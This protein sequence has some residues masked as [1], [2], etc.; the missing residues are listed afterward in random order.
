VLLHCCCRPLPCTISRPLFLARQRSYSCALCSGWAVMVKGLADARVLACKMFCYLLRCEVRIHVI[1]PIS[2]IT[3]SSKAGKHAPQQTTSP[4]LV[5]RH[6][7][8]PRCADDDQIGTCM[9]FSCCR[10]SCRCCAL[11][12]A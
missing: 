8:M 7:V 6:I 1:L 9:S 11:L 3:T 10:S 5:S 4:K 12:L 2:S